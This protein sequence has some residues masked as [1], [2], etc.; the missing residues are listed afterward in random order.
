MAVAAAGP[1]HSWQ[2]CLPG[3]K[4]ERDCNKQGEGLDFHGNNH[5][6]LF[7]GAQ[8]L[9]VRAVLSVSLGT[10]LKIKVL[11]LGFSVV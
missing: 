6:F 4:A 10:S 3:G 8:R 7:L 9:P 5:L 11:V 1:L 2:R